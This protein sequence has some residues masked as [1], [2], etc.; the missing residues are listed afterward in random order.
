MQT[1]MYSYIGK[2]ES[3]VELQQSVHNEGCLRH[4]TGND[5]KD[6]A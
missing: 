6:E 4:N 1:Y 2:V 5:C 3:L